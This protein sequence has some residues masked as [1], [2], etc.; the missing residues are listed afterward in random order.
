MIQER[1]YD[2]EDSQLITE[3]S[4]CPTLNIDSVEETKKKIASELRVSKKGAK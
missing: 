1:W 4:S 2:R 3:T